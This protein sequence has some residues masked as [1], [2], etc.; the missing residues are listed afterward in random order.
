MSLKAQNYKYSISNRGAT[1]DLKENFAVRTKACLPFSQN[2]E[3]EADENDE[4][5]D[6]FTD[7]EGLNKGR[8]SQNSNKETYEDDEYHG[9][10]AD[11]RESMDTL[12]DKKDIQETTENI[13]MNEDDA[14]YDSVTINMKNPTD[15]SKDEKTSENPSKG[16][17]DNNASDSGID[18]DDE[19]HDS[20]ESIGAIIG[21]EAQGIS[22]ASNDVIVAYQSE[23][24]NI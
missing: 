15:T 9:S 8:I 21:T 2:S 4:Y 24:N 22:S 16:S 3:H 6:S 20:V 14:Y 7:L 5:H 18:D 13:M 12:N 17:T 11:M 23:R 19:Y 10:L 1:L